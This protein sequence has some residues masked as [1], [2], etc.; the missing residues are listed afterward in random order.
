MVHT[1]NY[2]SS[3]P[4]EHFTIAVIY[5]IVSTIMCYTKAD[6]VKMVYSDIYNCEKKI[7][8]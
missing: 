1:V 4:I 7:F 3:S 8:V 2:V 6:Q 5:L